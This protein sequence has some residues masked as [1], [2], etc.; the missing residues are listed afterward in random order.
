MPQYTYK[1]KTGPDE[2]KTGTIQADNQVVVIKKL[3]QEG[4]Y[5]IFIKEISTG[6]AKE[7]SKKINSRDISAFTRQLSNLVRSGFPLATALSTLAQQTQNSSFK[8]LIT[9]LYERIQKGS[10]F[11]DALL[12]YPNIFSS[13]YI[14]MVK[15]GE[16]SGKIDDTLE[17]LADFKEREDDLVSQVKSALAYPAFL[18]SVGIMTIFI[19]LT[20]FIPRLV[21][22]FSDFGKTLPLPTQIIIQAGRF[23]NR[24]WWLFIIAAIA[25]LFF[26][27]S[28]YKIEKNKLVIDGFILRLPLVKSI[29]QKIE[30]ARFS[31]ALGVM[32]K[33]G[34]PVL[35]ALEVVTLS[36]N[37]SVFRKKISSFQEKIRKGQS[38]SGCLQAEKIFPP[39]LTNMVA[40]GEESGELTEMLFRIGATFE[41]EANRT[42]KTF[43]S[44]IEPMLILFIGGIV[45]L[46]VFSILLPIFQMDFFPK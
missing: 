14:N 37:N 32:L 25:T 21:N 19:L 36:V 6:P 15:I 4:L 38:L 16:T 26:A 24:F 30:I 1:A 3:R 41:T 33:S 28:Y 40:V 39:I 12:A 10:T 18:F 11:S 7:K 31:Y 35:E 45:V 29:I 27:K 5:P 42:V 17:R 9:D 23:M 8:K 20:F 44:L 22:M 46:M 43:V 13:F 2:I 34:V